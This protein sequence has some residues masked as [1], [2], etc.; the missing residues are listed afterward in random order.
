MSLRTTLRLGVLVFLAS[1]TS[2]HADAQT[3]PP[4]GTFGELSNTVA[5]TP[6]YY[7]FSERGAPTV[8]IQVWG[9]VASPG[10]YDVE[11][12]TDLRTLITLAGGLV[13]TNSARERTEISVQIARSGEAARFTLD[14]FD[15]VDL[16]QT[17]P[18]QLYDGDT[19][20][21]EV[22]QKQKFTFRD[23]LTIAASILAI[24]SLYDRLSNSN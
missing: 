17:G 23:G 24:L 12:G 21:I 20:F 16:L 7:Y 18:I 3:E 6:N 15:E 11:A 2:F 5:N 13:K 1:L 14:A 9:P 8:R 22:T 19:V 10:L 4:R